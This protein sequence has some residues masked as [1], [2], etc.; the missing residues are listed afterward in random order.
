[1]SSFDATK[2]SLHGV[3]RAQLSA[4]SSDGAAAAIRNSLGVDAEEAA[5]PQHKADAE[6]L[7]RMF[8]EDLLKSNNNVEAAGVPQLLDLA[9]AMASAD[10]G[11]FDPNTPFALLEDLFDAQV[12]S[13]AERLFALVEQRG[14]ALMPLLADPKSGMRAKL[15]FLRMCT[16]LARRLSKS[17]NTNFCGRILMYM[18]YVLPLSERSGVNLK[19]VFATTDLALDDEAD[20]ADA[21]DPPAGTAA[22]APKAGGS[23]AV[24]FSFYAAFWGLQ[25]AFF[26]PAAVCADAARWKQA[27]A[28]LQSVL[29]VFGAFEGASET[30]AGAD[31]DGASGAEAEAAAAAEA[32]AMEVEGG[33]EEAELREVYFSKFLTSFKLINLQLRGRVLPTPPPRPGVK[34]PAPRRAAPPPPP[35][36]LPLPH[37]PRPR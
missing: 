23:G 1:M 10:V 20:P 14:D 4:G 32:A 11:L 24:D 35:P 33:D 30:E 3:L 25:K 8:M 36:P 7:V 34:P 2:A 15:T 28:D 29:D 16:D 21:I 5:T 18:A 17:K 12:V 27:A 19:G 37:P 13:S 31:A 26:Q 6:L 9:I 22:A